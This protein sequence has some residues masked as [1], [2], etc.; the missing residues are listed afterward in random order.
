MQMGYHIQK[1]MTKKQKMTTIDQLMTVAALIH[2]LSTI[3]QVYQIYTTQDVSGISLWTWVS[4]MAIGTI[5][6]TYATAH[7]LAPII[8]SQIIWFVMDLLVIVGVLLYR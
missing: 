8:R 6:L 7:K 4:Y 5:Y 1:H 3:P 2:P